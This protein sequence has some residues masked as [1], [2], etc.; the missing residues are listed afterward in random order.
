MRLVFGSDHAGFDYRAV[1]AD[2]SVKKGY[3]VE[4]VGATSGEP[5]DYPC[6]SDEVAQKVLG[7]SADMGVLCCGT[8]IGVSIRA[9]RYNGIRA[10]NCCSVQMAQLARQHNHANVLC[11]GA[12]TT[13]VDDAIQILDAFLTT[14]ENTE[15]RHVRRVT[16][17]DSPLNGTN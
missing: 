8:G 13:S 9:N 14:Q 3:I 16:E 15:D 6:A 5:Y 17:L 1:L 7:G 2:W 12:R 10:A 11:L 4:E